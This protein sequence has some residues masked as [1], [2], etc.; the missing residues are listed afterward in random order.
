[1]L[2]MFSMKEKTEMIN[3]KSPILLSFL[4]IFAAWFLVFY[5]AIFSAAHI[6]HISE[7]FSHGFFVI[8]G[9][10]YFIWRE[11]EALAHL[12][13]QPNYW[14]LFGLIPCLLLGVLGRVGGIEVFAHISAFAALPLMLWLVMGNQ[15]TKVIWF[16]LCFILFSIPIGEELV[17]L[18]QKITA[19]MA[20]F[21]LNFTSIPS[22]NTGL[23][24]EI[25]AGKFVVAEAC[26]GIRFFIGSLVFGAVYSH[27]SYH[28]FKR[29]CAFM[30]LAI[31]VPILANALRV[32]SIVLIGHFVDMK[33]ASGADHLIYGW[34]F[35]G[36][37]LFL[38][39]MIGE[40]FRDKSAPEQLNTEKESSEK[41]RMDTDSAMILPKSALCLCIGLLFISFFW[42]MNGIS[43][44]ERAES[45]INLKTMSADFRAKP[46]THSW[47]ILMKGYSDFV[48][49]TLQ[50]ERFNQT[51]AVVAWYPQ[52]I[53]GK[54]LVA[55]HNALFDKERWSRQS[56]V[57]H[58][59]NETFRLGLLEIV[60]VSGQK[61][62]V[63]YWYQLETEAYASR[64]KT[65]IY[66][67]LDVMSAGQGGGA[68]IALSLPFMEANR[69]AIKQRL[70]EEAE[71][72]SPIVMNALPF[73]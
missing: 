7:I 8:P 35:F 38:L 32:F 6:W 29:K 36:I 33:Y 57:K 21:L 47:H 10:L 19:D 24:I 45:N 34:I 53:E 48:E 43:S 15:I 44:D 66:Q 51:S 73:K 46:L 17:P 42:K 54:E 50:F 37:V 20:I 40:M 5:E 26:S 64:S 52:N 22:F 65:K 68:L 61:R 59:I 62:F 71:R 49:G 56:E 70:F 18:L 23:Y 25:P 55:S 16:P 69:E 12:S 13:I 4:S 63:A 31:A 28:S 41:S 72:F 9:A 2:L 1:M 30:L 39:V 67:A 27:I 3:I 11:R 58:L 14:L 60:S